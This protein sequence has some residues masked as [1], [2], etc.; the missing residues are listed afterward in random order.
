MVKSP[1]PD[2]SPAR[3]PATDL[4]T[5]SAQRNK[6]PAGGWARASPR[7]R[8]ARA[9]TLGGSPGGAASL[10]PE[11]GGDSSETAGRQLLPGSAIGAKERKSSLG[12]N[13]P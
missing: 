5:S 6:S 12:K 2:A 11:G 1:A 7:A 9:A 13:K 4:L 3:S 8:V 10:P